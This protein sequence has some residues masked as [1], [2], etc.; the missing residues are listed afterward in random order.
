MKNLALVLGAGAARGIAHIGVLH[1]LEREKIPIDMIIGTSMG[2]F[3]GG[4]YLAGS[5]P[6]LETFLLKLKSRTVLRFFLAKPSI[7]EGLVGQD[8][9]KYFFGK[10]AKNKRIEDLSIPFIAVASDIETGKRVLISKGDLFESIQASISIPGIFSPMHKQ[11]HIL[12]DG[13]LIDPI[14]IDIAR[15]YAKHAIVV[16]TLPEIGKLPERF[17]IINLF[18]NALDLMEYSLANK[19]IGRFKKTEVF[20]RPNVSSIGT[21]QFHKAKQA[22]SAGESAAEAVLPKIRKII[23][24][25]I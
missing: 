10:F 5:L 25:Q 6:E 2:A 19:Y 21:F 11:N 16:D 1:V 8:R 14:P 17:G 12:V 7:K 20:I 13:D 24:D 4:F 15:R 9:F 23:R 22:I 3:I 18:T